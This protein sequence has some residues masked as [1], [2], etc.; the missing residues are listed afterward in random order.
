M[1]MVRTPPWLWPNPGLRHR[2]PDASPPQAFFAFVEDV[3]A[4]SNLEAAE[5]P[6]GKGLTD[7]IWLVGRD[8]LR[9]RLAVV[10][11]GD[12][13]KIVNRIDAL[14]HANVDDADRRRRRGQLQETVAD[15][16]IPLM[17]V[18]A[19]RDSESAR[20][21]GA[22][23]RPG[24]WHYAVVRWNEYVEGFQPIVMG[25]PELGTDFSGR[26]TLVYLAQVF[27][28]ILLRLQDIFSLIHIPDAGFETDERG[29]GVP[30]TLE[31]GGLGGGEAMED[32]PAAEPELPRRFLEGE[33]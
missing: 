18:Y 3:V 2:E 32:W 9:F 28:N 24:S 6:D 13:G 29:G 19:A 10:E 26:G 14:E 12:F 21:L 31:P 8:P 27:P 22:A 17:D 20:W 25:D 23:M 1:G 30:L 7:F 16:P 4:L 11:T 15:L 5:S 33:A